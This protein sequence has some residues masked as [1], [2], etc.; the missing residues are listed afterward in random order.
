M[1]SNATSTEWNA[2]HQQ[3]TRQGKYDAAQ[4]ANMTVGVGIM[5]AHNPLHGSGQAG[6]PHPALALGEDAYASQG[7]GMTD[8]RR[9]QPASDEAPHAIP[10]HAAFVAAP[11]QRAMP[12][13]PYLESKDPQRVV[14]LGHSV[15][16]DVSTHHRLQPF[17][18]FGDGFMHPSLKFG[19]HLVQFRLQPFTYRLPQH[20]EPSVTPLLHTD[21]CEAKK[22]ERLRFPF[23]TPLPLVDRIRTKLQKSR[24]FG[25][26]FQVELPHSFRKFRPELIGIRFVS[27][28]NH[29]V[30]GKTH[31]GQ[32]SS[33]HLLRRW[34]PGF[35]RRRNIKGRP[36]W[37]R[38]WVL[39]SIPTERN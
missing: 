33:L 28:S 1:L 29:D 38:V 8:G 15:I 5:I 31:Y 25:M 2:H 32:P 37:S 3:K 21:M 16:S 14:V 34:L 23:S 27:K 11:R 36:F 12:E 30:I 22:V 18:L 6:F 10:K 19:F 39:A 17:A 4:T 7:I 24:L 9:R 20:R 26:Q 13:P 35:V